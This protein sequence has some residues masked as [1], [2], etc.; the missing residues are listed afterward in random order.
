MDR[1][2]SWRCLRM[3]P[4]NAPSRGGS[5]PWFLGQESIYQTSS[6]LVRAFLQRSPTCPQTHRPRNICDMTVDLSATRPNDTWM[7]ISWQVVCSPQSYFADPRNPRGLG[8]IKLGPV[9][10]GEERL[11]CHKT[12]ISSVAAAELMFT[13]SS[14]DLLILPKVYTRTKRYC[15]FIQYGLNHYQ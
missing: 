9:R 15:P 2:H 10:D 4:N 14:A 12:T 13:S 8:P 11:T 7:N 5:A 1:G 6:R 3:T